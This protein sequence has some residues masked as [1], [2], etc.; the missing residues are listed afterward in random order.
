MR[1]FWFGVTLVPVVVVAVGAVY[2]Q[3]S[4]QAPSRPLIVEALVD[5]E[6]ATLTIS[7]YDFRS[8]VPTVTLGIA[9]LPVMSATESAVV[10]ALPELEP[11]TYLLAVTWPD[12]AGAVFYLA[13]SET[14]TM[15]SAYQ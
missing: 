15:S 12:G 1:G 13:A 3:A 6:Q 9:T 11:G 4:A 7:G 14:P 2:L 8:G 5:V 10:T